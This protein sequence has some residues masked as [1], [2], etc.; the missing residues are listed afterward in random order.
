MNERN[1]FY[2]SFSTNIDKVF[3][4]TVPRANKS[5]TPE[6]VEQR[7]QDLIGIG[8]IH[9]GANGRPTA[10]RGAELVLTEIERIV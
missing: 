8:I 9:H 7:M 3:N 1:S 4:M 10:I 6:F 2:L 5:L